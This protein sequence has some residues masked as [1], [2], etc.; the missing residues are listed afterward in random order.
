MGKKKKQ[1]TVIS[2]DDRAKLADAAFNQMVQE[3]Q[4]KL[5]K[6][7]LL[8]GHDAT[9]TVL[10][11][12]AFII[13]YLLQNTGL[14]LQ[15]V[16]QIVGP[17][18]CYKSTFA[19]EIVRWHI[20]CGGYGQLN[21]AETKPTPELRNSVLNWDVAR[22][23]IEDC[24]TFEDW[25]RKVLIGNERMQKNLMKNELLG[26]RI[27]FCQIV[28]SLMGKAS[29]ITLKK[30]KEVGHA[31]PHFPIEAREMAD[32]MRAFPQ[33]TLGW[34][35]TFVGVN[36][37]KIN[38]D[39]QTGEVD[40]NIPGGWSLKFQCAAIIEMERIGKIREYAN[41]KA[42]TVKL[43][44][45]KNSYG[46]DNVRI[47]VRFKTWYQE[48]APGVY[49]LHSRFEWWEAGIL[50]LA[51]GQGLTKTRADSLVPKMREVCDVHEK[52]GGSAGKLYWSKRLDV[53]S[54]DAMSAHDLGMLLETR[55]EVLTDLYTLLEIT[56]QPYFKPG[57][58]FMKQQQGYEYVAAQSDAVDEMVARMRAI[59][60]EHAQL[61]PT[62]EQY[63]QG[64][65]PAAAWPQPPDEDPE[66]LP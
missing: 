63:P 12:P 27:P 20:L 11:V 57:V 43:N 25:Q 7:G 66:E 15:C 64:V 4:A 16:Y 59:E 56:Q 49:R 34:P 50:F 61:G 17:Q 53:P 8:V 26:R 23:H 39:A 5:Q 13:R 2:D 21:E 35:F 40:Y 37:L 3:V 42:A 48:D 31:S 62:T 1:V 65:E 51:T 54:S 22:L 10:P 29:E 47:N 14:P 24:A 60:Q 6:K 18:G 28:D 9:I 19:V 55:P 33:D 45:L 46:A 41:Y 58:D 36:H 38:K 44:T 32:F 30:I 52:S